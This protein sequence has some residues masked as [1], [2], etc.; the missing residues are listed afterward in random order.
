MGG[1]LRVVGEVHESVWRGRVDEVAKNGWA[2][3]LPCTVDHVMD[4]FRSLD[5]SIQEQVI[6][7]PILSCSTC[8]SRSPV[9]EPQKVEQ[10]GSPRLCCLLPRSSR[11]LS[12]STLMFQFRMVVVSAGPS[13]FSPRTGFNS[14]VC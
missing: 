1:K 13:G 6:E 12:S 3:F 9:L 14:A 4:V 7:V 2:F 8:P 10:L 11:R 5:S